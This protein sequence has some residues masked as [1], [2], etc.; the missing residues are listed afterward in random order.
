MNRNYHRVST[1]IG[2][3][4]WRIQDFGCYVHAL[5]IAFLSASR[6]IDHTY[7]PVTPWAIATEWIKMVCQIYDPAPNSMIHKSWSHRYLK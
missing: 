2:W 7:V 1:F 6:A 5:M 4:R 3:R